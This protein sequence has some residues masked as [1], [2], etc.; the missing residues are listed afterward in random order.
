MHGTELVERVIA[1]V[2]VEPG[3]PVLDYAP[4]AGTWLD[5]PATPVP[6]EI[7]DTLTFPSGRPLSPG[8][9]RWLAFDTSLLTRF[10]W[11]APGGRSLTPRPLGEIAAEEFGEPW[12]SL[13]RPTSA[14][15]G[16]CF[17][18]PGGS[19]SRRVL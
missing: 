5:G 14:R 15:F 16:E 10:G 1:S 4:R 2:S 12:G 13:Y 3:R 18:L 19:D 6:A 7:L 8:L 11:F 9:R 17:L